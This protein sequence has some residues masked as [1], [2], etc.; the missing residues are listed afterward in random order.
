MG[1]LMTGSGSGV[2]G[3]FSDEA[4]AQRAKA[5]LGVSSERQVFVARLLT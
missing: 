2:Y 4:V 5:A 3:L 1:S